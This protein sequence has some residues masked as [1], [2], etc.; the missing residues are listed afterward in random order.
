MKNT[1]PALIIIF[2]VLAGAGLLLYKAKTTGGL[3]RIF[4]GL[5][6]ELAPEQV[7]LEVT[8]NVAP[9]KVFELAPS[10]Q[11]YVLQEKTGY[12]LVERLTLDNVDLQPNDVVAPHIYDL[13]LDGADDYV[14]FPDDP[15]YDFSTG[16]FTVAAAAKKLWKPE[17][18][19]T[20]GDICKW[21]G[22][23][24]GAVPGFRLFFGSINI[25]VVKFHVENATT[26]EEYTAKIA[27]DRDGVWRT[28]FG[29]HNANSKTIKL[30]LDSSANYASTAYTGIL[31]VSNN[32]GL[33]VGVRGWC[34]ASFMHGYV[35]WVATWNKALA[36]AEVDDAS[37]HVLTTPSFLMDPTFYNGTHF[38]DAV[39]GIT[40]T[41]YGGVVRIPAEQTWLWH[42]KNLKSDNKLHLMWFPAGSIVRIIDSSG[43]IRE[44]TVSGNAT[45]EGQVE[46]FAVS[47]DFDVLPNAT[48]EAI[49][50]SLKARFY[51]PSG[52]TVKLESSDGVAYSGVSSGYIDLP[53]PEGEYT[54]KIIASSIETKDYTIEWSRYGSS[55]EI[56]VYDQG[57]PVTHALVIVKDP[58]SGDVLGYGETDASGSIGFSEVNA[59]AVEVEVQKLQDG[60]YYHD[61]ETIQLAT[62]ITASPSPMSATTENRRAVYI[63]IGVFVIALIAVIVAIA[64]R[65]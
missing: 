35:A 2:L 37:R 5:A 16:S 58:V 42:I 13:Y 19:D 31:D 22:G 56:K 30:Y 60:I 4:P 44:W 62:Q 11:G 52:F 57:F 54:V 63:A 61:S 23:S 40:G 6:E 8:L 43:F 3:S 12:S 26:G 20:Q 9:G 33:T 18:S 53:V 14:F 65:R 29:V 24:S 50:P 49:V 7:V 48:V 28:L 46:D 34:D 39:S 25:K 51:V 59:A 15:A 21:G 10:P 27:V 47:V 41:P 64:R 55:L 17:S 1:I 36:A 38:I 32:N 45:V